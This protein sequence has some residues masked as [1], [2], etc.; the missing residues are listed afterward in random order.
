MNQHWKKKCR[1]NASLDSKLN[2]LE[3]CIE[4]FIDSNG[5][6]DTCSF[7]SSFCEMKDALES[8]IPD[9]YDI[10]DKHQLFA[11]NK[12]TCLFKN[13]MSEP[14]PK[15]DMFV[16][17]SKCVETKNN[18]VPNVTHPMKQ[19]SEQTSS[20]TEIRRGTIDGLHVGDK[21]ALYDA[22]L[23]GWLPVEVVEI[24]DDHLVSFKN[25]TVGPQYIIKPE[26]ML[27]WLPSDRYNLPNT[28][29]DHNTIQAIKDKEIWK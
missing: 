19:F 4:D 6:F 29:E 28:S 5:G 23:G 14:E 26:F 25:E 20:C 1:A 21:V 24:S 8:G 10:L 27:E 18:F 13:L 17:F 9:V 7:A 22:E 16:N 2:Y 15:S 11:D 3:A 12:I